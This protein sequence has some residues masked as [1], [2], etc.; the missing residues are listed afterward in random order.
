MSVIAGQTA[1]PIGLTFIKETNGYP[2]HKFFL[3]NIFLLQN[4][5]GNAG[6]FSKYV[7]MCIFVSYS[8][9]NGLTQLA[10]IV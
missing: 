7:F 8:W 3:S 10:K 4:S 2:G 9:P 6:K 1:G 5:T